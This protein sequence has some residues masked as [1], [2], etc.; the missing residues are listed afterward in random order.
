[1]RTFAASTK[2]F[3]FGSSTALFSYI[4]RLSLANLASLRSDR[5]IGGIGWKVTMTMILM[6]E[7][8][9]GGISLGLIDNPDILIFLMIS[10]TRR[11]ISV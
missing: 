8:I 2:I 7:I 3:M 11:Q 5:S 1:M 10:I 4:S 6:D 9:D